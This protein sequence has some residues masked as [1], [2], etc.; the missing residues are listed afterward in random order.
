M[1]QFKRKE[2]R[3]E[4]FIDMLL[5]DVPYSFS[6]FGDGE[7]KAIFRNAGSNCDDH[8]YF[9]E[10]GA[11]LEEAVLNPLDYIYGLQGLAVRT[12]AFEIAELLGPD[13]PIEWCDSDVF[14]KAFGHGLMGHMVQA[15]KTKKVCLVG[16]VYL[17]NKR[18]KFLRTGG[19]VK[20]PLK[21][22][23]LDL[24]RIKG[25]I[26][27]NEFAE[28]FAFSASMPT[29][30][31]IHELFPYIGHN[32]W[33]IDFGSVWDPCVDRPTRQVHKTYSPELIERNL[34]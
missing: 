3:L 2:R 28:V 15:L 26:Q 14:H 18:L 29:N 12:Q 6:R 8:K 25:E 4:D 1:Q 33:M 34:G 11:R 32:K 27:R 24:D 7:W 5:M 23:Y 17:H 13:H 9:P 10:M 21:D 31:I 30:V 19:N 16:P 20:V 22:C